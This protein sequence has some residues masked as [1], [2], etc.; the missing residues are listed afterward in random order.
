MPLSGTEDEAAAQAAFA[1][2]RKLR[3]EWQLGYCE[4]KLSKKSTGRRMSSRQTQSL[5]SVLGWTCVAIVIGLHIAQVGA[6]ALH[7]P[8]AWMEVAVVWTALV[9]LAT[10]AMEEGLQPHRDV[11]RY[12]QYRANIMVAIERFDAATGVPAKL[13]VMRAFER[14]SLEEM[15]IF[16]RTHAKSHFML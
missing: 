11:E 1:A 16:M 3:L 2:W 13:E 10:R 14:T 7:L 4:A 5:F 9:A 12:E 15:R 8:R 6:E